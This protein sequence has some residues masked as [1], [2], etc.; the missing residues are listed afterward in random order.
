MGFRIDKILKLIILINTRSDIII[1]SLNVYLN[2]RF[3]KIIRLS[4]N[5][6]LLLRPPGVTLIVIEKLSII[7]NG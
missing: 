5:Y 7:L 3:N 4:N 1:N 2:V 6:M